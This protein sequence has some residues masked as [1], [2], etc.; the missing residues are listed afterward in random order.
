MIASPESPKADEGGSL[1]MIILLANGM[2]PMAVIAYCCVSHD[3]LISGMLVMHIV[4]MIT[5]PL[6]ILKGDL[7]PYMGTIRADILQA[8]SHI[9]QAL[10]LM[11]CFVTF[12]LA[13]YIPA[14]CKSGLLTSCFDFTPFI[15]I[16]GPDL[17]KPALI[18]AGL[19]FTFVNP[20]VEELFWRVFLHKELCLTYLTKEHRL[21]PT[22][23]TYGTVPLIQAPKSHVT[24]FFSK[25]VLSTMYALYHAIL[26]IA[27]ISPA[28]GL[29]GFFF[30]LGF[31]LALVY[32]REQLGISAS[33][34]L[35]AAIDAA[36]VVSLYYE[37]FG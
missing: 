6:L 8:K 10:L 5:L 9:G 7:T 29:L 1:R 4:V 27:R 30:L 2:L 22:P 26:L 18:A 21:S 3:W 25:I 15:S 16:L 17:P 23:D 12:G 37:K 33:V 28:F 13:V 36:V 20:L 19:Y 24:S 31:G 11:S 34:C 14:S 32:T 35:H